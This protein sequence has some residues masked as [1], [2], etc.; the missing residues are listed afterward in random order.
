M[1][2]LDGLTGARMQDREQRHNSKA[3]LLLLT[4]ARHVLHY[5]LHA[6]LAQLFLAVGLQHLQQNKQ[7][8]KENSR[9]SWGLQMLP[10]CH[11]WFLQGHLMVAGVSLPPAVPVA[12][13][14]SE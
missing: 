14:H 5:P 9:E 13:I 2:G 3:N 4:T 1:E 10:H 7:G 6:V 8:R 11:I 12:S